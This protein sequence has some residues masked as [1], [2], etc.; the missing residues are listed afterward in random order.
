LQWVVAHATEYNIAS[1]NLSLG[2][3]QNWQK[4][5][6]HYG[7][8]DELAALAALNIIPVAASGNSFYQFASN[9]GVAYPA[10]DPN[11]IAVG[12]VWLNDNGEPRTLAVVPLT[13]QPGLTT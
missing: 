6:T 10:A 9:P 8:G 3:S 2:D 7:I 12:A 13:T 4:A 11:T 5:D 1:V